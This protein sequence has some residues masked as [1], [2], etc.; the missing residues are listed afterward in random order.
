MD[1]VFRLGKN[2]VFC[3]KIRNFIRAKEE[4][5]ARKLAFLVAVI[6]L[7]TLALAPASFAATYELGQQGGQQGDEI[8]LTWWHNYSENEPWEA[9]TTF[10]AGA[11]TFD[12]SLVDADWKIG[13]NVSGT[14]QPYINTVPGTQ[15][16]DGTYTI[17]FDATGAEPNFFIAMEGI[18]SISSTDTIITYNVKY[19][20]TDRYTA[21]DG[22]I[23]GEGTNDLDGMPFRFTA[24]LVDVLGNHQNMGYMSSFKLEVVP[25]P[26]AVWLLGTGLLGLFCLGRR[27]QK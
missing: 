24:S 5:M 3:L 17:V 21:T 16:L 25:I 14:F 12:A 23:I 18:P 20:Y 2:T 15:N 8:Y 10:V 19:T 7:A 11:P 13:F 4:V 22:I 27:R 1:S 6:G 9:G 26:G